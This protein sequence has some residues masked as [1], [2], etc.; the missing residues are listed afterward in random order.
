VDTKFSSENLKRKNHLGDL[1]TDGTIIFGRTL[2]TETEGVN[3]IHMAHD[4]DQ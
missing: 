1:G 3:W 4:R 2:R